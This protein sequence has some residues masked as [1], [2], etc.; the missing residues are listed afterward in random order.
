MDHLTEVE[1][2]RNMAAIKSK[3]TKPEVFVRQIMFK[4]GFRYCLHK[5]D[6]PGKPDLVLPK[7][8]TVV[9]V[10]GCFW[11]GHPG[12]KKATVP[13]TRA[14]F[15]KS[16]LEG[17][18]ERDRREYDLL[19][20]MGWRVLIVWQC[21]CLKTRSESLGILIENFLRGNEPIAEIGR[22]ELDENTRTADEFDEK[23]AD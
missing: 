7:W 14:D 1:R 5:K 6:L 10:N 3:N 22:K 2:S 13:E 9:F 19:L 16:K 23:V 17:N 4:R 12:C 15:W 21:A 18:R 11:H 8:K 20:S